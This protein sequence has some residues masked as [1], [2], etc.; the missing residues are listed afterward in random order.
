MY[1]R[2]LAQALERQGQLDPAIAHL[3]RTVHLRPD[4][5]QPHV[6]LA[7]AYLQRRRIPEGVE[8]LEAALKINPHDPAARHLMQLVNANRGL[9]GGTGPATAPR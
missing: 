8:Q 4:L 5:L 6:L 2:P 9:Q 3:E 7:S 1:A